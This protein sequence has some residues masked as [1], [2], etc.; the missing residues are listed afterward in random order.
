MHTRE[1]GAYEAKTHLSQLLEKVRLGQSFYITRRGQKIAE[2]R[3]ISVRTGRLALGCDA[4]RISMSED[5]DA[6]IPGMEEYE[7]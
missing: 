7:S 4:G 1:V 2:L 3:P 5:F 6:P